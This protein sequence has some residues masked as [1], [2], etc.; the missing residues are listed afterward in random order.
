MCA[1]N[2]QN[3]FKTFVANLCG[4]NF[5]ATFDKKRI[6]GVV[7]KD[8][9]QAIMN[10]DETMKD[11]AD[12][13]GWDGNANNT[14]GYRDLINS[15]W[16]SFD[17][18]Q[19]NGKIKGTNAFNLNALDQTE[20][21]KLEVELNNDKIIID[22]LAPIKQYN[23]TYIYLFNQI[24][25]EI[26][27]S[28]IETFTATEAN[29]ILNQILANNNEQV[30]NILLKDVSNIS[31]KNY[32]SYNIAGFYNVEEDPVLA[33]IL[34]SSINQPG[35]I[36]SLED[37]TN[38]FN[39]SNNPAMINE[40]FNSTTY[41]SDNNYQ[42][43]LMQKNIYDKVYNYI[44]TSLPSLK[45]SGFNYDGTVKDEIKKFVNAY[46]ATVNSE[47]EVNLEELTKE[48]ENKFFA[49][50]GNG[51]SKGQ[52]L[53]DY[54]YTLSLYDINQED[55]TANNNVTDAEGK[56][57]IDFTSSLYK[58]LQNY[59][60]FPEADI[61]KIIDWLASNDT[62]IQA[63]KEIIN[64]IATEILN[65]GKN[66]SLD[67]IH[68]KIISAIMKDNS[69]W[70]NFFNSNDEIPIVPLTPVN[71]QKP[72]NIDDDEDEEPPIET[73]GKLMESKDIT[74]DE[75]KIDG[76]NIM[77]LARMFK[78]NLK[79]AL[80]ASK[81]ELIEKGYDENILNSIYEN[82]GNSLYTWLD[83][84]QTMVK[85]GTIFSEHSLISVYT[86]ENISRQYNYTITLN[87]EKIKELIVKEYNELA[88]NE[89]NLS[90][91]SLD[92][93]DY[94]KPFEGLDSIKNIM[95]SKKGCGLLLVNWTCDLEAAKTLAVSKITE[96][97]TTLSNVLVDNGLEPKK[98]AWATT[99]LINYYTAAIN[100]IYDNGND[101]KLNK[102]N[103]AMETFSYNDA[104]GNQMTS[105]NDY[106]GQYTNKKQKDSDILGAGI[107]NQTGGSGLRIEEAWNPDGGKNTATDNTYTIAVN[108]KVL[109]Q[110]FESFL[111]IAP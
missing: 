25:A 32:T 31:L 12:F 59:G 42:K 29:E 108:V 100:N 109:L 85:R 103:L 68:L 48:I 9:F 23:N 84:V 45:N 104:D 30:K 65:G 28:N 22:L 69:V 10:L 3:L 72:D 111:S 52:A 61:I 27:N 99:T 33:N 93:M 15:F 62:N 88:V 101:D 39:Q 14:T 107:L 87:D 67:M 17:V 73:N 5:V 58:N 41:N 60:N 34:A 76:A 83:N 98:A 96:Y 110:K 36:A 26:S 2:Y 40:Y 16:N 4:G 44:N 54:L 37:I 8:E 64:T 106:F 74:F 43:A 95:E 13:S 57:A 71:P 86:Y 81:K 77:H 1:N 92:T 89:H 78:E 90:H 7:T 51:N 94:I 21:A 49:T 55:Y 19:D 38:Y 97:I 50:D 35:D 20:I 24:K 79:N 46:L 75:I 91:E 47:E 66:L 18:N 80:E 102:N 6:D 105:E 63:Y 53:Y 82:I 70:E 56:K 11:F